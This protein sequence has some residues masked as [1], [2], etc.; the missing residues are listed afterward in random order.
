MHS[1][2]A[3]GILFVVELITHLNNTFKSVEEEMLLHRSPVF[4]ISDTI[5]EM[6]ALRTTF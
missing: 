4:L 6:K 5:R 3:I 1:S 2:S